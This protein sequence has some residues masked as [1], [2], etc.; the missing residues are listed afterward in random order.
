ML[1]FNYS[2]FGSSILEN[3]PETEFLP[4]H[5]L[6]ISISVCVKPSGTNYNNSFEENL[7]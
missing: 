7:N 6:F 1:G 4:S 5:V 2:L 3:F